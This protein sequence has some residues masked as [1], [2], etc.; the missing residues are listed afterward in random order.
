MTPSHFTQ[1][2]AAN[3]ILG[4]SAAVVV[5]DAQVLPA[6]LGGVSAGIFLCVWFRRRRQRSDNVPESE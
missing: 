4:I 1:A 2:V 6:I 3:V 5:F